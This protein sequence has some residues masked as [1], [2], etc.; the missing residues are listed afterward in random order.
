MIILG[1]LLIVM[2]AAAMLCVAWPWLRQTKVALANRQEL[3]VAL[4]QQRLHELEQDLGL[5]KI[6]ATQFDQAKIELQQG[7]LQDTA[8]PEA[9]IVTTGSRALLW[10]L[11]AALPAFAVVLYFCVG[12]SQD[13][14]HY[15]Q[16]QVSN[17]Q[18][19]ALTQQLKTP[20]AVLSKLEKTVAQNPNDPQGWFLLG[21]LYMDFQRT[22]DATK[23]FAHA[24][25]LKPND[26]DIMLQYAQALFVQNHMRLN[27]Q[28]KALL[29]AVV[30]QD[31]NNQG[32]IN[33]LAL[34]AYSSKHYQQAIDYWQSLLEYNAPDSDNYRSLQAA[35]ANAQQKLQNK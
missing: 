4:F 5:G 11:L 24:N 18:A 23:A 26:P 20:Q 22:K 17:Q 9:A 3:N 10:G 12:G 32:V 31:P 16:Q 30:T 29:K 15:Q 33:L 7:L 35:I 27:S 34:D 6:D 25:Q 2:L 19:T 1:L 21:R 8:M 14:Y 13:L 28:A